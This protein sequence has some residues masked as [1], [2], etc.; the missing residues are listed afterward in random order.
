MKTIRKTSIPSTVNVRRLETTM[1]TRLMCNINT[2]VRG[3]R[4]LLSSYIVEERVTL[5]NNRDVQCSCKP[6][7][8]FNQTIVSRY[9][10]RLPLACAARS[11]AKTP[12]VHWLQ[13]FAP[14]NITT[15][16]VP[17]IVLCRKL[18]PTLPPPHSMALLLIGLL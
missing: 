7:K 8:V 1:K 14:S 10:H 4:C 17:N 9:Q 12:K 6:L 18:N 11:Y 5:A 16:L 13:K 15:S 3:L 2:H